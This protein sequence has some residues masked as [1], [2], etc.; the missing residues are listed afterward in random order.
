MP[1]L[2]RWW[3]GR[4]GLAA[5]SVAAAAVATGFLFLLLPGGPAISQQASGA[6]FTDGGAAISDFRDAGGADTYTGFVYCEY[7]GGAVYLDAGNVCTEPLG[8]RNEGMSSNRFGVT[9][10]NGGWG[11]TGA[12]VSAGTG[13]DGTNTAIVI[14][15]G[16]GTSAHKTTWS[17]PNGTN[18]V[19]YTQ[20]IYAKGGNS[21][22]FMSLSHGSNALYA[23][24]DLSTCTL[25][26]AAGSVTGWVRYVGGGWCRIAAT[27]TWASGGGP[28]HY[29]YGDTAAHAIPG[30]SWTGNSGTLTIWQPSVERQDFPTSPILNDSNNQELTRAPDFITAPNGIAN[31]QSFCF[32]GTFT[33][34]S[35][36]IGGTL[37][38]AGDTDDA[39]AWA[40]YV[41]A[42]KI[43]A[44]IVDSSGGGKSYTQT[45]TLSDGPHRICF[46]D[47]AGT[48]TV[49]VDSA[50]TAGSISGSG[51]GIVTTQPASICLGNY[52]DQSSPYY[53]WTNRLVGSTGVACQ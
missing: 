31:S 1:R 19:A 51:S 28:Q 23:T 45:G 34:M 4:H 6:L 53:G 17:V 43:G 26:D 52:L 32:C 46:Y 47:A 30:T 48:I 38:S 16:S 37:I 44:V 12:A 36:G 50:S 40:L 8:L 7:D 41:A 33:P 39:D 21:V 22:N 13:L 29:A 3:V 9:S 42:G 11:D 18:G 25:A 35:A 20:S 24:F 14:S 2:G 5:A 10:Y 49:K 27:D 15:V